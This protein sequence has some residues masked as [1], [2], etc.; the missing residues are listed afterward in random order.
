MVLESSHIC[1]KC[2]RIILSGLRGPQGAQGPEGQIVCRC[3]RPRRYWLHSRETIL[4]L[5]VFGLVIAFAITGFAA[6]LYH[7]RRAEL[8]RS[9]FDRGNAELKAG[10]AAQTVSDLRTALVYAEH[11]LPPEQQREYELKLAE[12]LLAMGNDDEAKS[13][14]L[15][16]WERAPGDSRVNLELARLAAGLG[17]GADAKRYYNGAIYGVW[18]ESAENVLRS[19]MDAR[20][21]FFRYLTSKGETTEGQGVLLA[22]AAETPPDP[23]LHAEVGRL[24]LQSGQP[25]PAIDQF[26]LALKLDPHNYEALSGMGEAYFALGNDR[27]AV[28][29]LESA[30]RQDALQ[31]RHPGEGAE[32]AA[33]ESEEAQATQDLAI[34]QAALALD[35][36]R[37]G[38][39]P[40]ERAARALRAYDAAE[41]RIRSCA[42]EHG[43]ALPQ[44]D[45]N[46][47][48]FTHAASDDLAEAALA[49]RIDQLDPF[50]EFVFQ[51]ESAAT[52]N[53]GPPADATNAAIAR[54]GAR[55][56]AHP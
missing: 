34:A 5:S 21:E 23:A 26:A 43:I 54:I 52:E 7:G 29:Y 20:L 35:P 28:R 27:E 50:M 3:S 25:Q 46:L 49:R 53:C 30:A 55:T 48:R 12:A 8:A 1:P 36:H 22:T 9:W 40:M 45:V 37:P 24:M 14:L 56:Q 6:R 13:Y 47:T 18:D 41:M 2:G 44:P 19:R 16:L 39:E 15:D 4:L 11:E 32:T 51:M 33:R 31:K 42:T 38:L 10:D 17:D